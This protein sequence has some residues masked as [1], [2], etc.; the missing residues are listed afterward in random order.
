VWAA[1]IGLAHREA[2]RTELWWGSLLQCLK[3]LGY[4]GVRW[5]KLA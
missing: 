3:D 2:T 4:D 5:M 1:K